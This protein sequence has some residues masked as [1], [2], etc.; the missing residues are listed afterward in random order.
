MYSGLAFLA[1]LEKHIPPDEPLG[2]AVFLMAYDE[3]G[4]EKPMDRDWNFSTDKQDEML[5]AEEQGRQIITFHFSS[6]T[7][8][9]PPRK[10]TE[11][12]SG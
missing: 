7:V 1:W 9:K 10:P 6:G 12:I 5:R 8:F 11:S 4:V 2:P 3:S